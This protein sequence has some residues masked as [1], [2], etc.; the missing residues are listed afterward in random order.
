M[1]IVKL[2][3]VRHLLTYQCNLFC[4]HC[5]LG[6]NSK[7][8]VAI[9]KKDEIDAFYSY[10]QP[11]VVSATG[12]EPLLYL[13]RVFAVAESVAEYGGTLE[14]VTNGFYLS[15]S[16]I[17]YLLKINE[18][19]IFQI[20]LDGL[21]EHHNEMRG[22]PRAF[23]MAYQAIELAAMYSD[24]VKARFTATQR[25]FDDIVGVI[26]LLDA[27]DRP[28]IELIIRPVLKTG[29]AL[30]NSLD[31]DI[32]LDRYEDFKHYAKKIKVETT[33]TAG[34]C[35]CGVDTLAIDPIGYIYPCTYFVY[36]KE[37]RLGSIYED[38]GKL[39]TVK[40]FEEYTGSCYARHTEN[41]ISL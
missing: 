38:V 20:S 23:E 9:F 29:R 33:D 39:N 30:T 4:K 16:L 3:E 40:Q 11:D 5:Y 34:K 12:G 6:C 41:A 2:S 7:N 1:H 26:D 36:N 35:G 18:K 31:I 8:A 15:E 13:G 32:P 37:L 25:N 10:Y 19:T 17:K 21:R 14:L 28:N 22:N 27:L 24:R